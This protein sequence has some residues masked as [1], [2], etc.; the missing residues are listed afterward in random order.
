[1]TARQPVVL[2]GGAMQELQSGDS[3]ST[4]LDQ[5]AAPSS[6]VSLASHK[7][8]N[9]TDPT[10]NQDAATKK[11][12]DDNAGGGGGPQTVWPVRYIDQATDDTSP[13]SGLTDLTSLGGPTLVDG[14]HVAGN[15]KIWAVASGTW[16]AVHTY[17]VGDVVLGTWDQWNDDGLSQYGAAFEWTETGALSQ[18]LYG[19]ITSA[20]SN[21]YLSSNIQDVDIT[22]LSAGDLLQYDAT[23]AKW[24]P[25]SAINGTPDDGT[26]MVYSNASGWTTIP[27]TPAGG[28]TIRFAISGPAEHWTYGP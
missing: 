15:N 7:L 6:D 28:D 23:A 21:L 26:V 10:S 27:G 8:T 3:L 16:T 14:D 24:K 22:G 11:Y 20:T 9:V 18:L 13:P 17:V 12:V 19:A 2:N 4:R 25:F 5:L 1:M